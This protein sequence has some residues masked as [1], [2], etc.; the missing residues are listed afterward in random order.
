L[1]VLAVL[2]LAA[3]SLSAPAAGAQSIVVNR[4]AEIRGG[5]CA[6]PG[7][8]VVALANVVLAAG[9]PLGQSGATPVEQSGTVVPYTLSNFLAADHAI[10]VQRSAEAS[11]V[12]ACGEIGGAVNPD[13]TLGVGLRAVDASGISGVAYFTP[14]DT[15][16]NVLVTVLLVSEDAASDVTVANAEP[17]VAD[18]I[19]EGALDKDMTNTD[20]E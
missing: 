8:L 6:A 5:T 19:E 7:A 13:G 4:P 20:P 16:S 17:G 3:V 11:E 2:C 1:L 15:F 18:P 14:I 10:F 12:V 9:D